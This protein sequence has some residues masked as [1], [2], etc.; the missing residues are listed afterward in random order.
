MHAD[1]ASPALE[2]V[3][4]R[5]GRT[6]WNANGRFQGHTDVPLDDVGRGQAGLVCGML[7]NERFDRA[8]ASDLG[9]ARETGEIVLAGR[10]LPIETDPRFRELAFGA[11]EGLNWAAIVQSDPELATRAEHAPRF[12]TPEGGESFDALCVRLEAAVAEQFAQAAPGS[13]VVLFTHAGPLHGLLRVLLGEPESSAISVRF[14]PASV[15]RF[16]RDAAGAWR[17]VSL[18]ETARLDLI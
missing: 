18:N 6:A 17:L 3:V 1:S 13:R 5:H 2:L 16:A 8:L 15:T 7:R 14:A 9:R 4:V 12:F 11:W 10:G